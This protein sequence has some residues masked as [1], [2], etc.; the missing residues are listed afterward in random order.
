MFVDNAPYGYEAVCDCCKI[1]IDDDVF[2]FRHKW[3]NHLH[4]ECI[5]G[6]IDKDGN[7]P[8]YPIYFNHEYKDN[9][10]ELYDIDR[11]VDKQIERSQNVKRLQSDLEYLAN[12]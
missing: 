10:E 8:E 2:D 11:A 7:S 3:V 12:L 6:M 5:Y 9:W 1:P 4:P